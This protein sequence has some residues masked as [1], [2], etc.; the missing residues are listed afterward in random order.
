M[1]KFVKELFTNRFGIIMATLNICYFVSAKFINFV[2]VHQHGENCFYYK[3]H[4]VLLYAKP[5]VPD[6][7]FLINLPSLLISFFQGILF[8]KFFPKFCTFTQIKI[9][10]VFFVIF[11]VLQWLFIGWASKKIARKISDSKI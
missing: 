5:N 8:L 1:K 4:F 10:I 2:S 7:G 9:Q 3:W 6:F 11:V